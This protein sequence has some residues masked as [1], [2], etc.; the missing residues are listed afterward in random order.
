MQLARDPPH[1]VPH[2]ERTGADGQHYVV[3]YHLRLPVAWNGRFLF[4]GGG[5]TN[6][7]LGF[8]NGALQ[9]GMPTGLGQGFAGVSTDTG[10]D[11][12]SNIDPTKQGTVAFGH[13]Y[14]ARLEY[15]QK[16]LDSVATTAKRIVA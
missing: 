10:H 1:P 4:Q 8:A 13:D 3:K 5:G 9:P 6:G 12:A 2:C 15:S 11:N 16:A 7:E 14:E